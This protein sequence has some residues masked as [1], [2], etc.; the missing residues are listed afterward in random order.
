[1]KAQKTFTAFTLACTLLAGAP[2]AGAQDRRAPERREQTEQ[3]QRDFTIM[4][5][6]GESFVRVPL[7]PTMIEQAPL[8]G[9]TFTYVATEMS[10][11]RKTVKGA[12]YSAEAV[13]ESLQVLAD[14]NRI[15]RKN[16]S[17][18]YRDSEGRTRREYTIKM[19]G[20]WA[21][22]DDPPRTVSINDPVAG[23]SYTLDPRSRTARKVSTVRPSVRGTAIIDSKGKDLKVLDHKAME[24]KELELKSF[25]ETKSTLPGRVLKKADAVNPKVTGAK[26][27]AVVVKIKVGA[28]GAVE[29]YEAVLNDNVALR[30]AALEAA[31][32]WQFKPGEAESGGIAFN[33][34]GRASV[35]G[36][37]VKIFELS[38]E[39]AKKG[40]VVVHKNEWATPPNVQTEQLGKQFF[41]GVEAEG[42]R[43]T[44]TIPAGEIGNEQ[45]IQIVSERW[46]SPELQVVVMTR[47]S[48][49]RVGETTYRLTN[50]T[51]AEPSATL[52]QVPADYSVKDTQEFLRTLPAKRLMPVQEN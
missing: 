52:F 5:Q 23:V 45:P 39:G 13:T 1:M 17:Q 50:I 3:Q 25:H 35:P 27:E 42:T 7:E 18:I 33:F 12:P 38:K 31:R 10:F 34:D 37:L 26:R 15:A 20:Q 49:P 43:T 36:E 4:R 22:E 48:D 8:R 9:D 30:N 47:Q 29:S 6:E 19:L 16:S 11:D 46:Y 51:R 32:Q 2:V 44:K 21:T 24:L 14:G 40:T 41:E 28:S